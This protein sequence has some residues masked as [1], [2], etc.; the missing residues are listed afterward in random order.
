MPNVFEPELDDAGSLPEPFRARGAEIGKQAGSR[1]LGA[2]LYELPRGQAIC[3]LHAHHG[4]EEMLIV[5]AGRPTLRTLEGARE[6][7]PGDVVSFPAGH[8]GAH[9]VDNHRDEPARVLM[10]STM[11]ALDVIEY[12]DSGKVQV[13]THARNPDGTWPDGAVRMIVRAG[14]SLGYFD[15]EV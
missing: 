5:L 8:A 12:P 2:S 1:E 4:N 13:R 15:G 14:E 11:R 9:R 10:V 3:P 7:A 6:L